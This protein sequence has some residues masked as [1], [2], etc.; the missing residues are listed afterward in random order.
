ML[1]AHAFHVIQGCLPCVECDDE[2]YAAAAAC[3]VA[4]IDLHALQE[5]NSMMDDIV[6]TWWESVGMP[7]ILP[8][9]ECARLVRKALKLDSCVA[10]EDY[11]E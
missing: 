1:P 4:E 9:K 8:H 6:K 2:D 3:F 7:T 10:R 11:N 5:S